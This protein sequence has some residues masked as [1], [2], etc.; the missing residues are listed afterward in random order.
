MPTK[1][2]KPCAV[3]G[4]PNLTSGTY[5]EKHRKE[6]NIQYSRFNRDAELNRF[7]KSKEWRDLRRSYLDR[8]PLC[9]MCLKEGRYTI[10]TIVDH[11]VPIRQ[12]GARLDTNNLQSL[13]HSCHT[14]KS[15]E[16]GSTGFG[17]K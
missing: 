17:R 8:H 3:S 5:C 10:A 9:A 4:C 16:E 2:L 11:I 15:N 14:I 1:P 7:Y 6:R 12:G 13:C